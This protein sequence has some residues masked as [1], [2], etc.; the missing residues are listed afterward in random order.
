MGN[1]AKAVET[2]SKSQA[3]LG[4]AKLG[5][6]AAVIGGTVSAAKKLTGEE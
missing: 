5:G 4:A 2:G 3:L 1:L 6:T